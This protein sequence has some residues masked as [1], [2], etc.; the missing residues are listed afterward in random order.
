MYALIDCNNFYAS[1]ERVFN[2]SLNNKPIIVLSNNDGCVIARSNESKA[3]GIKMGEPAFKIKDI[4][5]N[6][7]INVFSTN[8]ALYGD[9]S[10][11]VMNIISDI[12]P[13]IEIYSI[14]EAFLD[15][16]DFKIDDIFNLCL[17]MKNKIYKYTGIPVSIGIGR[18]KTLSKIAN[19]IAKK[20]KSYKGVFMLNE[21]QEDS[22]LD[23]FSVENIWGVGRKLDF[24]L[25][26]RN[27]KTAKLLRDTNLKWARISIN[28]IGEKI[29]KELR[30]EKCFLIQSFPIAKKSICTSRT[31]GNMVSNFEDLSSSVAMY[32]TRCAEKLRLQNSC[33]NFA[34]VFIQTNSFRDD[35]KQH[36][37]SKI[38]KFDVA[39]NDTSEIL[40]Y[41]LKSLKKIY[42]EGYQYKKAGVVVSGI[43]YNN[44]VQDNL[45]DNINR[46]KNK[47]IML[48]I[49]GINKKMGQDILRYAV[50]G[51]KKKYRLKQQR[52]SPCYTT[53]WS[54][55][56]I[57]ELK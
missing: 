26:S 14:D 29:I 23:Q 40:N 48:T 43:V 37:E 44:E 10:Q 8:F 9:I 53:R 35:L 21:Y 24:F 32:A 41:I 3:L 38:I 20:D 49:D 33:A 4:I 5:K 52:L 42:K 22:T 18:T 15:L 2:P 46:N 11:R 39:T 55:I 50:L 57:I 45:F 34:Y 17:S 1:C 51:Y 25:K 27:I 36:I 47:K 12:I 30:G 13:I 31:F 7:N 6:N 54:D 28:I 19:Y 16:N 56:L